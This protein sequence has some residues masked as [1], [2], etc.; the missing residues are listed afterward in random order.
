MNCEQKSGVFLNISCSNSIEKTCVNCKKEVCKTHIHRFE[1][2]D[3]C[4]NCYWEN[5]LY[6]EEKQRS[7]YD[8]HDEGSIILKTSS[9]SA[10]NNSSSKG[11][12]GG[13]NNGFGGGE[14]GGGG[15]SSGWTE[16]DVESFSDT[17]ET[18]ALLNDNDTFF[19]S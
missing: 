4:E 3:L 16:G 11:S 14:F 15:A 7:D 1:K 9:S 13:F 2:K 10:S 6:E 17:T 18:G 5:Y 12:E 8:Y 19:Y